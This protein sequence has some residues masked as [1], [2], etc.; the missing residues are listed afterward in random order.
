M[1][2]IS[3]RKSDWNNSTALSE[4]KQAKNNINALGLRRNS[5][6]KRREIELVTKDDVKIDITDRA[7]EFSR[8]KEAV[9]KTLDIDNTKK[10][11]DLKNKIQNG[12]YTINGEE[13]VDRVL[14]WEFDGNLLDG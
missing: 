4:A 11:A 1:S 5:A 12:S 7:K 13:L 8:I 10:I 6:E 14:A 9:D 2:N 3:P